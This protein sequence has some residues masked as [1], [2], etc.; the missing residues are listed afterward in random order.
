MCTAACLNLT[1]AKSNHSD[2]WTY[3]A[4]N[5]CFIAYLFPPSVSLGAPQWELK[6]PTTQVHGLSAR[7]TQEVGGNAKS[8]PHSRNGICISIK[9]PGDA[10]WFRLAPKWY[11]CF[12]T[13]GKKFWEEKCDRSFILSENKTSL[14]TGSLGNRCRGKSWIHREWIHSPTPL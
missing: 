12:M 5:V 11:T 2:Q 14:H 4:L 13:R 3:L 10:V 9:Y 1:W 7:H 8:W 6:I